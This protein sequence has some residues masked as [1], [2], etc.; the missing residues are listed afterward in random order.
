MPWAY[1]D[2]G[3]EMHLHRTI[4]DFA[5]ELENVI[6]EMEIATVIDACLQS[7]GRPSKFARTEN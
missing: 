6:H 2:L 7:L 3:V 5:V 1:R 4:P